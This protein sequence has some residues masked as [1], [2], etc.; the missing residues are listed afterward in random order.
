MRNRVPD[1]CCT[2]QFRKKE[3]GRTILA[4]H[5]LKYKKNDSSPVAPVGQKTVITANECA[6]FSK[7]EVGG[8]SA[9]VF[10]GLV[11]A[12]TENSRDTGV[13][14]TKWQKLLEPVL[15]KANDWDRLVCSSDRKGVLDVAK[16]KSDWCFELIW[17]TIRYAKY[18]N[19]EVLL[20]WKHKGI[21]TEV[22]LNLDVDLDYGPHFVVGIRGFFSKCHLEA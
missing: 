5:S 13:N 11:H 7:G 12:I 15:C 9:Q 21:T 14:V 8:V 22:R 6:D 19:Y 20:M 2:P 3:C 18:L 17:G 1:H 16:T 10:N 4:L